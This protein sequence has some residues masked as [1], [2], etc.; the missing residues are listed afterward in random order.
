[1]TVRNANELRRTLADASDMISS[2]FLP[3][4]P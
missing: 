1:M 3:E 2:R 4:L